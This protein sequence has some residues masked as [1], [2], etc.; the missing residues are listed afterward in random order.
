M[1]SLEDL[2][3]R[4]RVNLEKATV[5]KRML[6]D[7]IKGG[8]IPSFVG[9]LKDFDT[10]VRDINDKTENQ[11]FRQYIETIYREDMETTMPT[12]AL[13]D[14]LAS[15]IPV[16]AKGVLKHIFA[17]QKDKLIGDI[18]GYVY[19]TA[20]GK[21]MPDDSKPKF[22]P[23]QEIL[24]KDF[25]PVGDGLYSKIDIDVAQSRPEYRKA[26]IVPDD[27]YPPILDDG[28]WV[29]SVR[30][31]LAPDDPNLEELKKQDR[32]DQS[33]GNNYF[34]LGLYESNLKRAEPDVYKYNVGD[35]VRI[36]KENE[37]DE[38]IKP[39]ARRSGEVRYRGQFGTI[40][41][42]EAKE[43]HVDMDKEFEELGIRRVGYYVDLYG[44]GPSVCP[45]PACSQKLKQG[46][47]RCKN[48]ACRYSKTD[49]TNPVFFWEHEVMV[50]NKMKEA[51]LRREEDRPDVR[52]VTRISTTVD[53]K[54][55]L[56][57]LI[58]R[59]PPI[60]TAVDP[61]L[62][63]PTTVALYRKVGKDKW[64]LIG[65]YLKN[66]ST[67]FPKKGSDLLQAV[68][69]EHNEN[70]FVA[71]S[72]DTGKVISDMCV[73]GM[74]TVALIND[75]YQYS[76]EGD[77]PGQ[78]VIT[79]L[80]G[81]IIPVSPDM[82]SALY[83]PKFV[84]ADGVSVWL[85]SNIG[86][87]KVAK[88][89]L[90]TPDNNDVPFFHLDDRITK[91]PKTYTFTDGQDRK[92]EVATI[93]S[94]Y[95]AMLYHGEAKDIDRKYGTVTVT[96]DG[97]NLPVYG[98]IRC[99]VKIQ[100]GGKVEYENPD[101]QIL[102]C[103]ENISALRVFGAATYN[104]T[105]GTDKCFVPVNALLLEGIKG[106]YRMP[107]V[108]DHLFA[109]TMLRD[110][111][112][113]I[114]IDTRVL[115]K[116]LSMV[117]P[118]LSRGVNFKD[119]GLHSVDDKFVGTCFVMDEFFG[120]VT[121]QY[122]TKV[123]LKT[124]KGIETLSVPTYDKIEVLTWPRGQEKS[125]DIIDFRWH[126]GA[127]P[128]RLVKANGDFDWAVVG[129]VI[130]DGKWDLKG[131][132]TPT[133]KFL[134][135]MFPKCSLYAKKITVHGQVGDTGKS[136]DWEFETSISPGPDEFDQII[137][138]FDEF[139]VLT[140]AEFGRGGLYRGD[141]VVGQVC[142]VRSP[143]LD[144]LKIT[145]DVLTTFAEE[146]KKVVVLPEKELAKEVY[147]KLKTKNDACALDGAEKRSKDELSKATPFS[148]VVGAT[149]ERTDYAM[150][151]KD[152][153]GGPLPVGPM[154]GK[155]GLISLDVDKFDLTVTFDDDSTL[156]FVD[157]AWS[158]HFPMK[159][160]RL[161]LGLLR[162]LDV[163]KGWY[164]KTDE[165]DLAN[166]YEV[167]IFGES[168]LKTTD[169]K[170]WC[171]NFRVGE[172]WP[173]FGKLVKELRVLFPG[174]SVLPLDL[175]T[176]PVTV[177]E[178]SYATLIPGESATP[179]APAS[180][181]KVRKVKKVKKTGGEDLH[182]TWMELSKDQRREWVGEMV[183]QEPSKISTKWI[184]DD[185]AKLPDD[186]KKKLQEDLDGEPGERKLDAV[187]EG[188]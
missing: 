137:V 149:P 111:G 55:E 178:P 41:G 1:V 156:R 117:G 169:G 150:V 123:S 168:Y 181:K 28:K 2:A 94:R 4:Y 167:C 47:T 77:S 83:I 13:N 105:L 16:Y 143:Y 44:G 78:P 165:N 85:R 141:A 182:T 122:F 177:F 42:L 127:F 33:D 82:A 7:A 14:V 108:E 135:G 67:E 138:T 10:F 66:V 153:L 12:K 52:D 126:K 39:F 164:F 15:G 119:T 30:I 68:I 173:V 87:Q 98:W 11:R 109:I 9:D 89:P 88:Y 162:P 57:A 114:S 35:R 21:S 132:M 69:I 139:G 51:E 50:V 62:S 125:G 45:E 61:E 160:N 112:R 133:G 19:M 90:K 100:K 136:G 102:F 103:P 174:V 176:D 58:I 40:T 166:L 84:V 121:P 80:A 23:G 59:P 8:K 96:K 183:G 104:V 43:P 49:F 71:L 148:Y 6:G 63:G 99:S 97:R 64:R 75:K 38:A 93:E 171:R 46:S 147:E 70:P 180:V 154:A 134:F 187:T 20:E 25:P 130:P 24:I 22:K 26:T 106:L 128:R 172:V 151:L 37:Y 101:C 155:S 92:Y 48:P 163:S 56:D 186:L 74:E 175:P 65:Y 145:A 81:E 34:Y 124:S 5:Q 3:K 144:V 161:S 32:I 18:S 72:A 79:T 113:P 146:E 53:R 116:D 91:R 110:T 27:K 188:A 76:I 170:Q 118:G 115:G 140:K 95:S 17:L 120:R 31:R 158:T 131:S 142:T 129:D 157:N 179:V 73:I 185:L 54:A 159:P 36:R 152:W 29:Y 60:A 184:S 107:H 86:N